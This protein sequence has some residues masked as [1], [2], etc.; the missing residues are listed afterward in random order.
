MFARKYYH[1]VMLFLIV[2]LY[3]LL[4]AQSFLPT[5]TDENIYFYMAHLMGEGILPYRDFFFSHPIVHVLIPAILFKIFGFSI[6]LSKMIPA[7]ATLISGILIYFIGKIIKGR[8]CGLLSIL[9]F[10]FAME[11]LKASSNMTGVNCTTMFML[12]SVYLFIREKYLLSGVVMAVAAHTGLYIVAAA[13]VLMVITLFLRESSFKYLLSF[14]VLFISIF[15][16]CFFMG[17]WNYIDGVYIYHFKKVA[18]NPNTIPY[19]KG[20]N[21]FYAIYSVLHNLYQFFI[22]RVFLQSLYYHTQLY[23]G[24]VC[25]IILMIFLFF[26]NISFRDT[27]YRDIKNILIKNF[28]LFI[29]TFIAVALLFQFSMFKELYHFYFIIILGV[30]SLMSGWFMAWTIEEVAGLLKELNELDLK[31]TVSTV[32]AVLLF[33]V[34]MPVSNLSYEAFTSEQINHDKRLEY[35]W[36]EPPYLKG[37]SVIVKFLFWKDHRIMGKP[38]PVIRHYL[39]N[40]KLY[41]SQLKEVSEYI[42]NNSKKDEKIIGASTVVPLIALFSQ[43]GIAGNEI[44]TNFKRFK[45]GV[46]DY[47]YFIQDVCSEKLKFIVA[48]ARSFFHYR[49]IKNMKVLGNCFE[50][51]RVFLDYSNRHFRPY[52]IV[53]FKNNG[54]CCYKNDNEYSR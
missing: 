50:R 13:M 27:F 43:R 52:R 31:K 36:T 25:S 21:T 12:L 41:F 54:R 47:N 48:A 30:L 23:W 45:T 8:L 14:L 20:N 38:E 7:T 53:L 2:I 9:L 51:D 46:L 15:L 35:K 26:K 5:T 37:P 22:S 17:S 1:Y 3:V 16:I 39:W 19:I 49:K 6:F 4:K 32:I 40:K 42:K 34:Y 29:I 10:L 33:L 28:P 18:Q 11:V 44:D 24:S